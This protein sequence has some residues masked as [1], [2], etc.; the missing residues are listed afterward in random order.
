VKLAEDE[1]SLAQN[2]LLILYIMNKVNKAL[3]ED[4]LLRIVLSVT[5]MNY[6]YLKQFILDLLEMKY[7]I[8]YEANGISLYE[9]TEDGKNVLELTENII[10]GIKKLEVDSKF[11]ENMIN[12]KD[13]FAVVAEFVPEGK[14]EYFVTL[15][16][17][18]NN[19]SLVDITLL[20]GSRE[21]ANLI[22]DNW[23]N[24]AHIIYPKLFK[25]LVDNKE[26]G[27]A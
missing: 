13:E 5:D 23:K 16:I 18:E 11:K 27:S 7:I 19:K 25:M 4:E 14:N 22:I 6:F 1:N 8:N 12:I 17:V 15:K 2:K 21:Q 9:V 24:S 26:Q 20:A 10:P 3:N